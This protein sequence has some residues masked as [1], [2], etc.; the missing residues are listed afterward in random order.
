VAAEIRDNREPVTGRLAGK[1]AIVTGA[2]SRGPGIG[3]GKA[4]AILFA[5]EGAKV[6]LVNRSE[7]HASELRG[8]IEAEGGE[9]SVFAADVS[10][11]EQVM[12]MVEATVGRHGRLDILCSNVGIGG[13]GTAADVTEQ[14]WDD[15]MNVN[16]KGT[17]WCCKYAIPHMLASGGGSIIN[18]STVAAVRGVRR[19]TVGFAAYSASKAG[20]IGLTLSIA[21]D[22]ATRGIRANCLIVGMVNTPLLAKFG[23]EAREKRRLAVPMQTEGTG[24]DVGW[25]AVYLA[26]DES[27]WVTGASI[28]IDGGQLRLAEFPL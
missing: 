14:V 12:E 25:A 22:Y 28:P 20:V 7:R 27:R 26:S 16:L 2:A 24:W 21:A 23:D 13:P 17:L 11:R 8:E 18:V 19:G 4:I 10:Q 15:V 1:V 5:R 3:I 6:V 9:C